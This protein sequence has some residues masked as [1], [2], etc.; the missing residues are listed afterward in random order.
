MCVGSTYV[1]STTLYLSEIGKLAYGENFQI[2]Y[3]D[4]YTPKANPFS[5]HVLTPVSRQA[6][7]YI[8]TAL[9]YAC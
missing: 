1:T 9:F 7:L 4:Q 6:Q 2:Y 8:R 3:I 5:D